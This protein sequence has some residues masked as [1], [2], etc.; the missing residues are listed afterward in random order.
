MPLNRRNLTILVVFFALLGIASIMLY[1]N[2]PC[3]IICLIAFIYSAVMLLR[4]HM[5]QPDH[6]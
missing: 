3:A 5:K 2:I 1:D 4:S 6:E